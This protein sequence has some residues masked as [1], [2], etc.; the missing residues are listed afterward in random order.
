M[1]PPSDTKNSDLDLTLLEGFSF[2]CR[3]DCG[4]C[5]YASP[6]V[7]LDERRR[8]IAIAPTVEVVAH[9]DYRFLASHPDGGSCQFLRNHRCSVHDARPSPCRTFPIDVHV[10]ERL[11]A[12][13]VLSCPGLDLSV[14]RSAPNGRP[15][16]PVRGLEPEIAAVRERIPADLAARLER[17]SKRRRRLARSLEH[18]GRW[19]PEAEVR[20][21]LRSHL[22]LPGA[23]DFDLEEPP[24][25][26]DGLEHLPLF[27]DARPGPVAIARALGGWELLELRAGGGVARTLGVYPP[28]GR[29]PRLTSGAEKLLEGYLRYWL[30]RDLLFGSVLLEMVESDEGDVGSWIETELRSIGAMTLARAS[31]R[32]RLLGGDDRELGPDDVERGIRA[33]DQDLLDRPTWG[34]RL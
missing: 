7:T 33:T 21:R 23:S 22:P 6:R 14:L 30:E 29:P 5:C 31:T 10:G 15:G 17:S 20:S 27:F 8:L 16:L 25:V 18:E 32:A 13:L 34:E 12:T 11:Q 28:P 3:P 1:R 9:G 4:L 2:Q 26:S 24:S 19:T